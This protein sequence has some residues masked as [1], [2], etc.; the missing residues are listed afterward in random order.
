MFR[1]LVHLSWCWFYV[2]A[3]SYTFHACSRL[4]TPVHTPFAAMFTPVHAPFHGDVHA[5]AR[6]FHGVLH[7]A[8]RKEASLVA[9]FQER[10]S[11]LVVAGGGCL[12]SCKHN[13]MHLCFSAPLC[14]DVAW[15]SFQ[16]GSGDSSAV[17]WL[18]I[19]ASDP[20]VA[21]HTAQQRSRLCVGA[22]NCV[23]CLGCA[24]VRACVCLCVCVYAF[25]VYV[26]LSAVAPLRNNAISHRA[27]RQNFRS[28]RTTLYKW[29][30]R[31]QLRRKRAQIMERFQQPVRE[32]AVCTP[33][34]CFLNPTVFPRQGREKR[35]G[36]R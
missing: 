32:N 23:L 26:C 19:L 4:F 2:H 34:S 6:T 27:T 5:C 29:S 7:R 13:G 24:C 31:T 30:E 18:S 15:H 8:E 20:G 35:I 28:L 9:D 10:S 11:S 25:G 12:P 21:T 22:A 1:L 16:E 33:G 3:C 36:K 17:L 14:L